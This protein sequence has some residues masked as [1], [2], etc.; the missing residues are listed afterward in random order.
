MNDTLTKTQPQSRTDA[1][2][3][4]PSDTF[5]DRHIG[6]RDFEIQQMLQAIGADSLEQLID[7]TVPASIRL[8]RP[9]NLGEP[10]GE[11][12]LLAELEHI[13]GKNKVMRSYIGMG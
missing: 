11:H 5:I 4:K 2:I 8:N 3:L 12:E 6:P 7:Q 10:R 13:A 9:L 1:S